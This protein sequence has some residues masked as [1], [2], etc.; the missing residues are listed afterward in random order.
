MKRDRKG[1]HL[2][3]SSS[4]SCILQEGQAASKQANVMI[5]K[6]QENRGKRNRTFKEMLVDMQMTE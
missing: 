4:S 2:K 5:E 1:K 3:I 6:D